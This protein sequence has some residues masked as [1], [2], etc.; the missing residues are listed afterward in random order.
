MKD[1]DLK[2]TPDEYW[3]RKLTPEQYQIIRGKGTEP[4]FSGVY[5]DNKDNGMYKCVA[6]GQSLFSSNTKFDSSTGWP[7]FYQAASEGAV[8]LHSDTSLGMERT[9]VICAHCGAHLGHVFNDGPKP[10]GKR[11]CINSL[12]L[13]FES[14]KPGGDTK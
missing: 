5:L 9:E 1:S 6:C 14:V 7:S 2:K 12:A 8:E 11:Y 13:E 10:S 3:R 4:A